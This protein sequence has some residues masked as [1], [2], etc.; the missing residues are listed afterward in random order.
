MVERAGVGAQIRA[1]LLAG[2]TVTLVGLPQCLAYALMSGLPPAYGLSTAAV[3]GGVAAVAGLSPH[4]VTGPTNTTGLLI[5]GAL[6]PY[7]GASGLLEPRGLPALATLTLMA[8]LLRVGLAHL[9]GARLLRYLPESVLAGFTAGAGVLIGVMQLDEALGLPPI[10]GGGLPAEV[11]GLFERLG[12]GTLPTVVGTSFCVATMLVILLG[13]RAKSRMPVALFAIVGGGLAAY[14]LEQGGVEL[15]L[16]RDRA[17]VPSGWPPGALPSTDPRLWLRLSAPALAIVLLG[18]LELTVSARAGGDRPD[19]RREIAAQGWAN[20]AGAFGSAFPASASLTRSALLRLGGARTR[21]AAGSAAVMVVPIL[22]F[23]G[24]AVG[25]IPQASLAG[26]L[27]VTAAGMLNRRR[28]ARI[29]RVSRASRTLMLTTFFGTLV[30]PLEVAILLG[31]GLALIIHLG[32][33]GDPRIRWLVRVDGELV[34]YDGPGR[35][36]GAAEGCA[37][38]AEVSGTLYYAAVPALLERLEQERPPEADRLVVDLS[39]AHQL[40][41]AALEGFE[42]Y[43]NRLAEVG[44]ELNLAGVSARFAR[45]V[46][47]AKSPLTYW[48]AHPTPGRSAKEALDRATG[49]PD[50]R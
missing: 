1:D 22:F 33:S 17:D 16:V 29:W 44:V 4:V 32:G 28:L 10:Q 34:P 13:Q 40:R 35:D 41:F 42:I 21:L 43:A 27:L 20:V 12:T 39:H 7:L 24:E 30:L 38:V 49:T 46:E 11:R 31:S 9:G 18:T 6:G 25:Y 26:V 3:S 23:A 5:L 14:G 47:E 37:V 45:I 15:L 19:M 2:L 36:G 50:G 48:P 8:G